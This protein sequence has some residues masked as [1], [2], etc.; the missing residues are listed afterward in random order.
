MLTATLRAR[1]TIVVLGGALLIA[2]CDATTSEAGSIG[3]S[4]SV[5]ATDA[6]AAAWQEQT[7]WPTMVSSVVESD[8]GWFALGG[9]PEP[10]AGNTRIWNSLDGL[11]WEQRDDPVLEAAF[12][13]WEG[14][15]GLIAGGGT[16]EVDV[17]TPLL[18]TSADGSSWLPSDFMEPP[19]SGVIRD[20][21]EWRG[22]LVATG[23]VGRA[24]D[25]A[26]GQA[27][28]WTSDDGASWAEFGLGGNLAEKPIVLGDTLMVIGGVGGP[29]IFG[30]PQGPRRGAL[31]TTEDAITWVL[32][33]ESAEL[34]AARFEDATVAGG[35][36]VVVGAFWDDEAGSG[37]PAVWTT[38][39][40]TDWAVTYHAPCCGY[41]EAVA[42]V[43]NE[44]G[45]VLRPDFREWEVETYRS[46]DG[47]SWER[48]GTLADAPVVRFIGTDSYGPLLL[49][50]GVDGSELLV[51]PP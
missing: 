4:S 23:A 9:L 36:L 11:A 45:A 44:L 5:G 17:G 38:T 41:F 42:Q 14:G 20:L 31:W 1:M 46:S 49:V 32:Q 6:T 16:V 28:A 50:S 19:R 8:L 15:P 13:L 37:E 51:P 35:R 48:D 3:P 24:S 34:T 7:S 18:W 12:Y 25:S 43:G 27:A 22:R 2:G 26:V 47:R 33:P 10:S 29:S 40:G 21:V 30:P 39:D